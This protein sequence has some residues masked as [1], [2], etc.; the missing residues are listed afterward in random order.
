M[1]GSIFP[2]GKPRILR[3]SLYPAPSTINQGLIHLHSKSTPPWTTRPT[4]QE[5]LAPLRSQILFATWFASALA[6]LGQQSSIETPILITRNLS[7]GS[8]SRMVGSEEWEVKTEDKV[9]SQNAG[10]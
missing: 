9:P 8:T 7:S 6:F 1:P 5:G 3:H 10:Y 4:F 2:H